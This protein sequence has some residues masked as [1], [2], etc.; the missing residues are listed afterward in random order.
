[1][2][3]SPELRAAITKG[4][5]KSAT[6]EDGIPYAMLRMLEIP[7]LDA[8]CRILNSCIADKKTP[9]EWKSAAVKLLYKLPDTA[10][11][12]DS[13]QPGNY[14]GISLLSCVGKT[15]ERMIN[16]RLQEYMSLFGLIDEV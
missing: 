3:Q 13:L 2:T 14:R 10:P 5:P 15:F 4:E 6:G 1:M 7:A 16:T 11:P 9:A 12:E 8:I